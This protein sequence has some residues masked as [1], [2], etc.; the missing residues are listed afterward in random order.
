M[1]RSTEANNLKSP[2]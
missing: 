1:I 2:P